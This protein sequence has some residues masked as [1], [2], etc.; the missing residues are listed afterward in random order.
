MYLHIGNGEIVEKNDIIGIFDM[1]TATISKQTKVFLSAAE[2]RK[3]IIYA[4]YDIPKSFIVSAT[5]EAYHKKG[6]SKAKQSIVFSKLSVKTL[7]VRNQTPFASTD[8]I[9]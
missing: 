4:G 2:K 1:D 8:E 9:I 5:G 6:Q 7:D 3:E